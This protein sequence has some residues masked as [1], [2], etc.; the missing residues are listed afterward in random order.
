M[1]T[2]KYWLKSCHGVLIV[3]VLNFHVCVTFSYPD[4]SFSFFSE[5]NDLILKLDAAADTAAKKA[6]TFTPER[7]ERIIS[8]SPSKLSPPPGAPD[9]ALKP[10]FRKGMYI[11]TWSNVKHS[12]GV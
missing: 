4:I 6:S 5:L 7:M 1:G 10:E 3:S 12:R 11:A 9:W 8:G 2:T